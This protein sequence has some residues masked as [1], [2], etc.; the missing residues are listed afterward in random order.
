MPILVDYSATVLANVHINMKNAGLIQPDL[1]RHMIINS[2]RGYAKKFKRTYG[3]MVLCIDAK[4]YWRDEVFPEYKWKRRHDKKTRADDGIDWQMV[5]SI[6]NEVKDSIDELFHWKVMEI[7][8][9][10]ADDIIGVIANNS[11]EPVMIVSG[12]SDFLQLHR[13]KVKQYAP[14]K[15]TLL[16][17]PK[18]AE[19]LL[20][21]KII[22]G[23]KGDGIPNIQSP[24]TTFKDGVRQ[25]AMMKNNLAEW[26]TLDPVMWA[27]GEQMARYEQNK[28]LIDLKC[29]P[30]DIQDAILDKYNSEHTGSRSQIQPYLIS[31][32]LVDLLSNIGDF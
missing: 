30:Q 4:H 7:D 26:S 22:N 6:V 14:I 17:L 25:K 8:R 5:Y 32:K 31:N 24:I 19:T 29:V 28:R 18:N 9:C 1:L 23:D 15:G 10:E 13:N 16:K 21:E 3:E 27:S 20:Q 2:H 11:K 12:D